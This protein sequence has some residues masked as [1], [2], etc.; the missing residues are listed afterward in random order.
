MMPL[1]LR[2][3]SECPREGVTDAGGNAVKLE[4][5]PTPPEGPERIDRLVGR[6]ARALSERLLAHRQQLFPPN[7]RKQLRPFASGEVARLL[8]VTDAYLREL[9]LEGRG[10]LFRNST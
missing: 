8:G 2:P 3:S 1:V 4:A 9:S 10:A 5:R 6:H 7:A